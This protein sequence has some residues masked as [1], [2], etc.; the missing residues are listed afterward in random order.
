MPACCRYYSLG[1]ILTLLICLA[2]N[3]PAGAYALSTDYRPWLALVRTVGCG[4]KPTTTPPPL[5]F[6]GTH[7][8]A[9]SSPPKTNQIDQS[10][11]T[12]AYA[13][14][15][16]TAFNY[17]AYSYA[18]S[19]VAPGVVSIYSTLQPLGTAILSFI[20]LN[21]KATTGEI[22]GGVLVII[23]LFVT[24][25]ARDIEARWQKK[26]LEAEA[27]GGNG[28]GVVAAA[29]TTDSTKTPLVKDEEAGPK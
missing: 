22:L 26:Q 20:F 27:V 21:S 13:A 19:I 4:T 15:F 8:I 5:I 6:L 18:G 23:G 29:L 24:V 2:K 25:A 17:N 3:L 11:H 7:L 16:G 12:Q 1:S 14:V 10:K 28:G 9:R